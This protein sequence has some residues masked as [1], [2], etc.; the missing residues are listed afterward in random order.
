MKFFVKVFFMIFLSTSSYACALCAL[1]TPTAHT[2]I[3]FDSDGNFINEMEVKW[4]FSENFTKLTFESYDI[5]SNGKLDPNEL[6]EVQK[7]LLD[8]L[9]PRHYLMNFSYY[10][11]DENAVNLKIKA[12]NIK[13]DVE[14]G[15]L[16]FAFNFPL[17][18]EIKNGRVIKITIFDKEDYFNFKISD[19]GTYELNKKFFIKPNV[20]LNTAFYKITTDKP[21][22]TAN[23]PSLQSL[24]PNNL[25]E[26]PNSKE[27]AD[28]DKIDVSKYNII[29]RATGNY[30][31]K[32]KKLLKDDQSSLILIMLISF[33]YG[34]LHAAG[35]GH[36]KLLTTSYFAANGGSYLK[37]VVLSLK[38]GIFHVIGALI[39]VQVSF[40]LIKSFVTKMVSQVANLTTKAS[41]IV[42]I[43]IA[44]FMLFKKLKSLI[45]KPHKFKII[46]KRSSKIFS[47]KSNSHDLHSKT[48]LACSAKN[49]TNFAEWLVVFSAAMVPCP[50]TVIVF[51]L[52]FSIGSYAVAFLSASMIGLGM[53]SVIFISAIFGRTLNLGFLNSKIRLYIE[54][55]ALIIMLIL[56]ISMYIISNKV[57]VL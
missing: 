30:L 44:L 56:G 12:K 14:N 16:V 13:T 35:P 33:I 47:F 15:R 45:K 11:G 23:K 29:T 24:I 42:I 27:L 28:I 9:L 41:A 36:G 25:D 51:I 20:N 54:I 34:F 19:R 8:Y 57:V 49:P 52:A 53:A 50:G 4:Y 48:C 2:Q 7:S 31:E 38:I 40:I 43:L 37:A 5:N 21:I 1:Y 32:L 6:N 17:R 55:V 46:D 26:V 10:D 22:I 18:L 3:K 39:L